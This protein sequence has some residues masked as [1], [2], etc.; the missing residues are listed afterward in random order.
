M[1]NAAHKHAGTQ[2]HPCNPPPGSKGR[3][4]TMYIYSI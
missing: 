3:I 2:T 4:G 1:T